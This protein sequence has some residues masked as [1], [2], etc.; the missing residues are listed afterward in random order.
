MKRSSIRSSIAAGIG[1]AALLALAGP[2]TA[3][4]ATDTAAPA[5]EV[6]A[7]AEDDSVL[8]PA[9]VIPEG[10]SPAEVAARQ[11]ANAE[12]LQAARQQVA[13]NEAALSEYEQAMRDYEATLQRL[14]EEKIAR[15]A[16]IARIEAAQQAAI[17]K[18]EADKAA[19]EAGDESRC[20]PMPEEAE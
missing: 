12:Q 1:T 9:G 3:Q 7:P 11:A 4:E 10:N 18:W 20:G 6:A 8:Q 2:L 19:C 5:E 16:E 15:E 13:A 17:E 14:E